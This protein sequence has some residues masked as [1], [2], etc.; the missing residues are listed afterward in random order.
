MSRYNAAELMSFD[1]GFPRPTS[2]HYG[3]VRMTKASVFSS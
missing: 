3:A 1:R 2:G